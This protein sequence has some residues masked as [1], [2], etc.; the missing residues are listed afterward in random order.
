M[1]QTQRWEKLG[2]VF[3]ANGQ[4]EWMNSHA[5]NPVAVPV[6]DDRFRIYFSTRDPQNRSSIGFVEI[7]LSSP[8][9]ILAMS[10]EPVVRPGSAGLFDDSGASLGCVVPADGRIY[11]YYVGWNLGVTVPW[12][13]SI[14]LAIQSEPDG[15]FRRYT[16]APVMDRNAADP[17]SLSYP[18]VLRDGAI[19]KMWYGSNLTWGPKT[20]DMRHIIKYAESLDGISWQRRNEV[21]IGL[22]GEDEMAIARP[23]VIKDRDLY[24]MWYSTR[25]RAYRIGYAESRDGLR[26]TR[27]DEC[28]GIDTSPAGWDSEMIEYASVFTHRGQ[29]YMLYNG[30][31][32]G[33]T[34]FGLARLNAK[35][36]GRS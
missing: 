31:D 2:L 36:E 16:D 7:D 29:L 6:G 12:R 14:G 4:F 10:S 28:A 20:S 27:H 19:W 30:N 21:A 33:R 18:W 1:V 34:G 5:A 26:W 3:C 22:G 32:Y 15:E 25:G 35:Q 24:R 9:H 11:L 17:Y 23:C 13:N 8:H